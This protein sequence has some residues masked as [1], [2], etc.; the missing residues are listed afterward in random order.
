MLAVVG[1]DTVGVGLAMP[2]LP[3]LLRQLGRTRDIALLYGVLMAA[4]AAMQF[5]FSPLLGALSDRFGRRP[6][7]LVSLAGAALDYL[8]TAAAPSVGILAAGRVLAGITG[9]NLA[10]ATSCIADLTPADQRARRFGQ[11]GAVM[12]LGLIAGPALGGLL[13]AVSLRAP[14][15]LGALLNAGNALVVLALMPETR[16]EAPKR[17]VFRLRTLLPAFAE[18]RA[19]SD[20]PRLVGAY[21][22]IFLAAQVPMSL[23]ILYCQSRY[24][25]GERLVGLSLAC[26]GL[27]YAFGQS[28]L[29]GPLTRRLGERY[30]AVAGLLPDAAGYLIL[31]LASQGWVAFAL[32]PLWALGGVTV[33]ALQAMISRDVPSDRQGRLQGSLVSLSSLIGIPGPLLVTFLFARSQALHP[34]LLWIGAAAAELLAL[35]L[36][37]ARPR[38]GGER[39]QRRA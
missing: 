4:Y 23:W 31:G 39:K 22:I 38:P 10:V 18:F 6:V 14:Y 8:V 29:I 19:H 11:M 33:P 20:T 24:G 30:S 7:L 1:I 35:P 34:G 32:M 28:V 27:L 16:T 15:L 17:F 12:G 25:W 13:G 26:Y 3:S 5:L 37:F 21:A 2:V 9:A 36:L